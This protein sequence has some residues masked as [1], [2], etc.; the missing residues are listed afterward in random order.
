MTTVPLHQ[1]RY[2]HHV[3]RLV[4]GRLRAV[5]DHRGETPVNVTEAGL[6]TGCGRWLHNDIDWSDG[7]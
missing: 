7:Q 4:G 3:V 2:A 6:C 5:C 1:H